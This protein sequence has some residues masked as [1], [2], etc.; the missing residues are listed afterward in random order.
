VSKI[1]IISDDDILKDYLIINLSTEG[2]YVFS[3][4]EIDYGIELIAQEKPD[5]ILIKFLSGNKLS[6]YEF[7]TEI[8]KIS[9]SHIIII[10]EGITESEK[11][12]GFSIGVNEYFTE[13]C[14]NFEIFHRI[15]FCIKQLRQ[16]IN[17]PQD[18]LPIIRIGDLYI[19]RN[20]HKIILAEEEIKLRYREFE[21]L[22]FLAQN[23]NKI[24]T[25]EKILDY[26]WGVDFIGENRIVDVNISRL[27][28]KLKNYKRCNLNIKSIRNIG[29]KCSLET[30]KG[31]EQKKEII[32][33]IDN[34]E[35]FLL[36]I[37]LVL[38]NYIIEGKKIIF[39]SSEKI[40]NNICSKLT[41]KG[42]F[43]EKFI[44][45]GLIKFYNIEKQN[46]N[47]IREILKINKK[48]SLVILEPQN[49]LIELLI[50]NSIVF[51]NFISSSLETSDII[52]CCSPEK[53]NLSKLFLLFRRYE[54]LINDTGITKNTF[55]NPTI[56]NTSFAD[57]NL[58]QEFLSAN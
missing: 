45:E 29:Y 14:T 48:N 41:V 6:H 18:N 50:Y 22:A 39:L 43:Y 15:K 33:I 57:V 54:Y 40:F 47:K 46:I 25:R 37:T 32:T 27:R 17:F 53:I 30:L 9:N 52:Y 26:V 21:I 31:N 13:S 20:E 35:Q 4:S 11:I 38:K 58:K 8:R 28:K 23:L 19:N 7:C 5:I 56:L 42:I 55:Y 2:S 44:D 16:I 1:V 49:N 36:Q 10:N 51:D 3:T 24:V 34:F 12:I